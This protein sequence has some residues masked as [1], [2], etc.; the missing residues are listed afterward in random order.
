[1]TMPNYN[2]G[3]VGQLT[4]CSIGGSMA[5]P[6]QDIIKELYGLVAEP[7]KYDDFMYD[8]SQRLEQLVESDATAPENLSTHIEHASALVDV[9]TPWHFAVDDDLRE[10]LEKKVN[11]AFAVNRSGE[12]IDAN[13]SSKAVYELIS[14][15]FVKDLP[16]QGDTEDA[17]AHAIKQVTTH[18]HG[19]NAPSNVVRLADQTTGRAILATIDAYSSKVTQ[20]I[21]AIVQTSDV[22]WPAHLGPILQDLFKFT[23][24]EIDVLRLVVE[25]HRVS[26]IMTMRGASEATVR[27]QLAAIFRKSGTTSQ[28]ECI[29]MIM[30]LAMLH[31]ADEG[32]AIADRLQAE[33]GSSYYPRTQQRQVLKLSNGRIIDYSVFGAETGDTLLFYHCQVFGDSWF[34][35]AVEMA[36]SAGLR[37]IAPLRPGFG[38][39]TVYDGP[40]CDPQVFSADVEELLDH[41]NVE[42]ATIVS[43]SSGLVHAVAAVDRM[44]GRF[45]GISAT[46]PILPVL[47]LDDLEGTNGYNYLIPRARLLFPPALKLMCRAGFAFVQTAGAAAFIRALLRYAPKDVEWAMR[48]DIFPLLEWGTTIHAKQGY[49]GNL[50]DISYPKDWSGLLRNAK[51]PVRL[52][53]GEHDRNVPWAAARRYANDF[54]HISLHVLHDS[55]YLVHHQHSETLIQWASRDFGTETKS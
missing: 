40:Y 31:D 16:F 1:M 37:I 49:L 5:E 8:L 42:T 2:V 45:K 28:V 23:R 30:G 43:V 50:G 15:M 35:E 19:T 21:V 17:L 47:S 13:S 9:V 51:V 7:H 11:S 36:R 55:G 38:Q 10:L 27:S 14:G 48:P 46:H 18:A 39:T 6:E 3:N 4:N 34:P 54:D 52:V 29:R 22:A 12:I 41:E 44:P 24:A 32:R 53:I 25:G 26:E 33:I 20:D